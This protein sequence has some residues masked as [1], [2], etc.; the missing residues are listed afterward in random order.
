MRILEP[1]QFHRRP[2]R[3][4]KKRQ[5]MPVLIFFL[6]V[7]SF[8]GFS[9]FRNKNSATNTASD[10]SKISA[11]KVAKAIDDAKK[12]DNNKPAVVNQGSKVKTFTGSEFKDLYNGFVYPNTAEI[13]PLPEITG[14]TVADN[15]IRK[16]AENRGYKVR[17]APVTELSTAK[18]ALTLGDNQLQAFALDG[19]N[20]IRDAATKD[21][22]NIRLVS[23]Y[24]S[25]DY[26]RNL[27]LQ[28]IAAVGIIASDLPAGNYD[29]ELDKVLKTTSIPGY[30]RHHTGYTVDFSCDGGSL[31]AF[32][33]SACFTW[34][35]NNNYENAKLAG[36]I[37]SYPDGAGVQGPDPEPWEYV[38]VGVGVLTN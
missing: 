28:R 31:E 19:W 20:K 22:H 37:P 36:W 1:T 26:Q 2:M 18:D 30:S 16:K 3:P 8:G 29:A 34:I 13:T 6:I 9:Y 11:E 10:Q 21:G 12:T 33:Q 27:F 25:V 23:T 38:W 24:R 32:V 14:N 5:N 7:G 4:K 15:Y 35:S 17:S